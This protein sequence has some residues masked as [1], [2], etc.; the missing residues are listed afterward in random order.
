MITR[1]WSKLI[2][3]KIETI[4]YESS[5]NSKKWLHLRNGFILHTLMEFREIERSEIIDSVEW[6]LHFIVVKL[7]ANVIC[8]H[9]YAQMQLK[10]VQISFQHPAE[11][12]RHFFVIDFSRLELRIET[13]ESKIVQTKWANRA[14]DTIEPM[15]LVQS[16]LSGRCEY[17]AEM[18]VRQARVRL[19][20]F[21]ENRLFHLLEKHFVAHIFDVWIGSFLQWMRNAHLAFSIQR[22]S[23]F[24]QRINTH[25]E[26]LPLFL[27][28]RFV[29]SKL[30]ICTVLEFVPKRNGDFGATKSRF[31]E[32]L[33]QIKFEIAL[34]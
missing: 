29:K 14:K 33:F 32:I 26:R 11:S 31:V 22:N 7:Q 20:D 6:L 1:L 21:V 4:L 30:F 5:K 8:F 28:F 24:L 25:N 3:T 13:R 23:H 27:I 16:S 18:W 12:F 10:L 19:A 2:E 34:K 15:N 9:G 17:G